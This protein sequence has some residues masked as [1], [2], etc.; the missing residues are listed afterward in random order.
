[1]NNLVEYDQLVSFLKQASTFEI[2]RMTVAL[3]NELDNPARLAHISAKIK[4]NDCVEWYDA[5]ANTFIKAIVM[6]K[7]SKNVIVQNIHDGKQWKIPL[8]WLKLDSREFVFEQKEEGLNKNSIKVGDFV[9]FYHQNLGKDITGQV[10]RLNPK[11]V[12]IRT[13]TQQRWRVSYKLLYSVIDGKQA[14]LNKVIELLD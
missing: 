7:T 5:T 12:S 6:D 9:G 10:E 2:Y 14:E 1:M 13:S 3:Q 4:V 11:T 8:Y